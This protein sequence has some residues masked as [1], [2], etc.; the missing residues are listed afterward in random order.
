MRFIKVDL[1]FTDNHTV[2]N[3]DRVQ[4]ITF[5][6]DV[7]DDVTS[8]SI[9]AYY[10]GRY[11]TSLLSAGVYTEREESCLFVRKLFEAVFNVISA[12]FMDTS[13]ADSMVIDDKSIK[14]IYPEIGIRN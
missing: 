1:T 4:Q 6:I 10:D 7:K 11:M 13:I 8:Y 12:Y 5:N 2:I 14:E 3:F 9:D